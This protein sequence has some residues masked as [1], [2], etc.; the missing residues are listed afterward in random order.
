MSDPGAPKEPWSQTTRDRWFFATLTVSFISVV[1]LF[2]PYMYVLLFA[3]VTV[4]VCWPVYSWILKRVGGRAMTASVLT[5]LALGLLVF[6]PLA[7]IGVMFALELQSVTAQA[8]EL[9]QSGELERM[10]DEL[11]T[12]LEPPQWA[13][14]FLPE[15]PA[16]PDLELGPGTSL[17]PLPEH[18]GIPEETVRLARAAAEGSAPVAV[19][20]W[21]EGLQSFLEREQLRLA[22]D[23]TPGSTLEVW[24][25]RLE[26]I[27]EDLWSGAQNATLSA[28]RFAGAEI[29][30]VIQAA[31][32]LSIDSVIYL[33]AVI[34]LFTRGPDLLVALK[35]L[36]PLDD[37]Y[38]QRLFDVFGEFSRNLVVG[39]VATAGIQ[40]VAA[41]IGY[42]FA[43]V[44]NVLF[45][46]I[47]TAIGSF[48]PVVGT[49]VIWLPVVG[50]LLATGAYGSAIF[51]AI[52]SLV[53]VGSIDNVLKPLFMRGNTDIHALLVFLAV[54]GG[55]YWAGLTGLFVGP[56]LVAFFLALYTIYETDYLG[57][58]PEPVDEEPGWT[59]RLV[60]KGLA[61]VGMSGMSDWVLG[62]PGEA[63]SEEDLMRAPVEGEPDD[64]PAGVDEDGSDE[65]REDTDPG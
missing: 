49:V 15:M 9:V 36:S 53:V 48:V 17:K 4:V 11:L 60:G 24:L 44:G 47:L 32:D 5:T 62:N 38:E 23:A 1:V 29:P 16:M 10:A 45:L 51:L 33:F 2:W 63:S 34:T 39:S 52:W 37:R 6:G 12:Q 64:T 59:M 7:L 61:A 46:A 50:Y 13:V 43:G 19:P 55:L 18:Q 27:E 20:A 14:S 41:G 26:L 3:A 28:L 58:E 56:V 8:I 31:V 30:G 65:D 35:R 42:G 40:G 57:I 25:Q 54:F 22:A 21:S